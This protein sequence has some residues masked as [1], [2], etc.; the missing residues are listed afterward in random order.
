MREPKFG[1]LDY[2]LRG[3]A[4]EAERDLVFVPLGLN[5]DRTLEDRTLLL[6]EDAD[7]KR[8]SVVRTTWTTL[9]FAAQQIGLAARS[10]WYRFGY[11]CVNF[12]TPVSMRAYAAD[13]SIDFRKLS[14]E[15]R[16]C[17]V[18]ELGHHLM[19]EV[20]RL[21]PVLPVPLVAT[22]LVRAGRPLSEME[23]KSEVATL[24]NRLEADGAHVYVPR[25]DWD[26]AVGAGLRML[27]LRH[28]V[29]ERD[30]LYAAE[31]SEARLL[32]YYSNSIEHLLRTPQAG[33]TLPGQKAA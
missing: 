3:F 4:P 28:L 1:V 24:V 19:N 5:Y 23:L 32:R 26:Y 18:A 25:S 15:E 8:P 30:G 33:D 16:S 9:Q 12:G 20:G 27:V 17:A 31:M 7:A 14:K 22:V 11:A 10:K 2:M 13:R 29:S 21:I 6:G